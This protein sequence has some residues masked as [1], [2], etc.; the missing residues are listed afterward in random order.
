M[1]DLKEREDEGENEGAGEA[2][3]TH[4]RVHTHTHTQI[5]YPFECLEGI[6]LASIEGGSVGIGVSIDQG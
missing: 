2:A 5:L 1:E 6:V 3:R 4:V